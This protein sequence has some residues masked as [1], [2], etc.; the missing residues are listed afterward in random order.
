MCHNYHSL[1]HNSC[2]VGEAFVPAPVIFKAVLFLWMFFIDHKGRGAVCVCPYRGHAI[3]ERLKENEISQMTCFSVSLILKHKIMLIMWE[4]CLCSCFLFL[5][6]N[7]CNI[8]LKWNKI[9]LRTVSG[10]HVHQTIWCTMTLLFQLFSFYIFL[11]QISE[12]R[13]RTR[14]SQY[15]FS[16]QDYYIGNHNAR[17]TFSCNGNFTSHTRLVGILILLNNVFEVTCLAIISRQTP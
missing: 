11:S 6:R 2:H 7:I 8:P 9:G 13:D 12:R 14:T 3:G 17:R 10:Q 15:D 16:E 4:P 5:G 1:L